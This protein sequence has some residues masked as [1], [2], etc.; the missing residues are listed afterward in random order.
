VLG[1]RVVVLGAT[2]RVRAFHKTKSAQSRGPGLGALAV[3]A[4]DIQAGAIASKKETNQK[5]ELVA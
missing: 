4:E 3:Y 1:F 5:C 2:A